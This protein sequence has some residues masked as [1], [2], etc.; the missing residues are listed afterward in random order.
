V[1]EDPAKADYTVTGDLTVNAKLT[2]KPG[3][4]I[5]FQE[6][7]GMTVSADGILVAMGKADSTIVFTG[8]SQNTNGFWR[9][10]N[11]YSNSV[12]NKISYA[13]ISYA[14]SAPAGTFFDAANLTLNEAQVQLSNVTIS[15]S[16]GYGIQTDKP[17]AEF[18]MQNMVF[19]ENDSDHAYVHISQ[20]GY[21][22]AASTF[23]GGY[24]TAFGGSTTGDMT[25]TTL[26]GAKY[27]IVDNVGFKHNIT[28]AEGAVFEFATDAGIIIYDGSSIKALGTADNKIVFTGTS[29]TPGAWKGIFIASS[30]VENIFEHVDISYGGSSDIDTFFGKTNMAL[31]D[32]KITLRN[33]SFTGS[34]GYGLQTG[35]GSSVFTV[36]HCLFDNNALHHMSIHP[37]QVS[38]IDS[39]TNFNGGDVEVNDGNTGGSGSATW[40]NL[41][42]GTYYFSASVDINNTVTIEAGAQFEMGTDVILTV[43]GGAEPG[44]IKAIGT[45]ASPIVFT[46]RSKAQG[47]WGG[48]K[49]GSSSIENVMNHV[50]IEYG[51]GIDLDTFLEAANLGV[52]NGG[53]LNLSNAAI[54]NSANYGIIVSVD[55]GTVL[56]NRSNITYL[57][58]GNDNL[59]IY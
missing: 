6:D 5:H 43:L 7:L 59:Y 13:E 12:E 10:I 41:N 22:D 53:Y 52:F 25:I 19:E 57:A 39:Q 15:H 29:K 58:N 2:V 51:G 42:N 34:A 44:V 35:N 26:N 50:K 48:I 32:A 9:G 56:G 46:G 36:E 14:G 28:I 8:E 17:D 21:F 27:K 31:D 47:A 40:S 33:V 38:F 37:S 20:L 11:I 24:V 45:S 30:S 23:D 55:R 16:G 54:E 1:Y 4:V 18:P 49:I 3:V